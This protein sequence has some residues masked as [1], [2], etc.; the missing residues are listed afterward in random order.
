MVHAS[1]SADAGSGYDEM[2]IIEQ[3]DACAQSVYEMSQV[4]GC[5]GPKR[6]AIA[7]MLA[8]MKN[9]QKLTLVKPKVFSKEVQRDVTDKLQTR[10]ARE[11]ALLC[12]CEYGL[13]PTPHRLLNTEC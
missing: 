2:D 1:V 6:A 12:V 11:F 3:A 10:L 7:C 5:G 9:Q 8:F 4:Q 13:T